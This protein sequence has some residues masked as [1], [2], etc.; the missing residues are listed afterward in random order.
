MPSTPRG[1]RTRSL[2]I[3]R[4]AAVFDQQGFA[5]ATLNHLVAAT[6][7]TRGAFYFHFD[8]KDALAE[9]IVQTQQERWLPIVDELEASEPDPMRRLLRLTYRSGTL[10][11][12]DLVMRAGS[13]LMTERSLI[14]RELW[15]SYPW[16]VDAIRRL[17]S[18]ASGDLN[19]LS[20]LVSEHWPPPSSIPPGVAPGIAALTE[21][22]VGMW[23]GVLQQAT[24]AGRDD[25]PERVRASWMATLP[26]LCQSPDRCAELQ[27]LVEELTEQ[28]REAGRRRRGEEPTLPPRSN[29]S[30]GAPELVG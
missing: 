2:I 4:T 12:G 15:R 16:W 21:H 19:D 5:G 25:L 20:A 8:S 24:A 6:G 17:L 1:Q 30:A 9:A 13:R 28:M 11:Q 23:T 27:L 14:R 29:A 26:W 3:E 18:E 22:L 7:L 10:F